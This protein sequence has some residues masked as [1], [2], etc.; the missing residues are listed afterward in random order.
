LWDDFSGRLFSR[1]SVLGRLGGVV[2]I[3]TAQYRACRNHGANQD[4][5]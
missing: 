1:C 4:K 3:A 5:A 2:E